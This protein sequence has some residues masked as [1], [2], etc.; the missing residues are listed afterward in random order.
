MIPRNKTGPAPHH[1]LI[2]KKK[3]KKTTTTAA[4]FGRKTT[5]VLFSRFH[6]RCL[7]LVFL[8]YF[9]LYLFVLSFCKTFSPVFLRRSDHSWTWSVAHHTN[10]VFCRLL[11]P[12]DVSCMCA[13]G[14]HPP[15]RPISL[16]PFAPRS[17]TLHLLCGSHLSQSIEKKWSISENVLN[18]IVL[19]PLCFSSGCTF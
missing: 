12:V 1:G 6:G 19:L 14:S 17:A 7:L 10:P 8:N 2:W 16:V 15:P 13:R 9:L 11:A 18:H 4:A 3:K 5:N